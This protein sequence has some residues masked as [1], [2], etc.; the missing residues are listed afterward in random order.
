MFAVPAAAAALLHPVIFGQSQRR[1]AH[2]IGDRLEPLRMQGRGIDR[3]AVIDQGPLAVVDMKHLAGIG[4][5]TV[6]PTLPAAVPSPVPAPG[7]TNPSRQLPKWLGPFFFDFP[8]VA[9]AGPP[10]HLTTAPP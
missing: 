4:Q 10:T 8:P 5:E 2:D 7:P 3:D 9:P 6:D 1:F